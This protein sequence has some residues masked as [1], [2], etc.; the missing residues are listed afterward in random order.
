M[1]DNGSAPMATTTRPLFGLE[2]VR[3]GYKLLYQA[4]IDERI[5]HCNNC[6]SFLKSCGLDRT[7]CNSEKIRRST[8]VRVYE[9]RIESNYPSWCC[10]RL[11]DNVVPI[12]FDRE[13]TQEAHIPACCFPCCTHNNCCPTCSGRCGEAVILTGPYCWEEKERSAALPPD[14]CSYVCRNACACGGQFC[15]NNQSQGCFLLGL[16]CVCLSTAQ[17]RSFAFYPFIKNS[18]ILRSAIE[19]AHHKACKKYSIELPAFQQS[20]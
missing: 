13:V 2:D 15:I 17:V 12:Y 5:R 10:N 14:L 9:N 6:L 16:C 18:E 1:A 3:E 8:Y 11:V 19:L 20:A 4:E 7:C